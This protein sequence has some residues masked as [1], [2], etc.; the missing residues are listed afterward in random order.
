M[1][2][3]SNMEKFVVWIEIYWVEN[4][5]GKKKVKSTFLHTNKN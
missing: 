1:P 5:I 2:V 3:G 4:F